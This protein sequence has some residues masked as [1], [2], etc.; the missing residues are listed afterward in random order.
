MLKSFLKYFIVVLM[1][2]MIC[3]TVF[4]AKMFQMRGILENRLKK[5]VGSALKSITDDMENGRFE[6]AK[7]KLGILSS[8]WSAFSQ[9]NCLDK[10]P[11]SIMAKFSVLDNAVTPNP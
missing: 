11:G 6:V 1:T 4:S 9:G 10:A 5:P 7:S 2:S 8:E 3:V